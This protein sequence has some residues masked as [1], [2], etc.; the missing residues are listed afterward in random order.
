MPSERKRICLGSGSEGLVKQVC[1][2]DPGAEKPDS[3]HR[4]LRLERN[5]IDLGEKSSIRLMPGNLVPEFSTF[6]IFRGYTIAV[7]LHLRCAGQTIKYETGEMP[8]EILPE[9]KAEPAGPDVPGEARER[10]QSSRVSGNGSASPSEPSETYLGERPP[11][12]EP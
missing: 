7:K 8:I 10:Y 6:N 2:A 9:Y 1:E 4:T 12:Y 3:L 5:M 11:S